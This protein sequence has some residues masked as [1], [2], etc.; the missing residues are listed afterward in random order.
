[1][2]YAFRGEPMRS[3][4]IKMLDFIGVNKLLEIESCKT[5][6]ESDFHLVEMTSL[7]KRATF[8]KESGRMFNKA[9]KIIGDRELEKE[10][11][12]GFVEDCKLYHDA[13]LFVACGSGVYRVLMDLHGQG[14]INAPVIGIAHP[15]GLNSNWVNCYLKKK[16]ADSKTLMRCESL[17]KDAI[18]Q[19]QSLI[20][21][22]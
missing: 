18:A 13:K 3:N 7:L 6:W 5:I 14:V 8:E 20:R 9:D 4:L 1:M 10:L 16:Q 11:N 17:R 12:K 19:V 22:K 15:S 21:K 2:R